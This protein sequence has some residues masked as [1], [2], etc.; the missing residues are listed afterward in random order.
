MLVLTDGND[1][2]KQVADRKLVSTRMPQATILSPTWKGYE[3][4][5]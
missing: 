3:Y 1:Q 5:R 4:Y 2:A